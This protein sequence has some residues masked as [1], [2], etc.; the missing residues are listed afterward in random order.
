MLINNEVK[1]L[2]Q[3]DMYTESEV[4]PT[5]GTGTDTGLWDTRGRR[6]Y[7]YLMHQGSLLEKMELRKGILGEEEDVLLPM[8]RKKCLLD[9]LLRFSF[10]GGHCWKV[11]EERNI[12]GS[13]GNTSKQ[14]NSVL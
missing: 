6:D 3:L 4:F 1:I 13:V 8:L 2:T 12:M 14:S 11:E 10:L 5:R 7:C 9:K